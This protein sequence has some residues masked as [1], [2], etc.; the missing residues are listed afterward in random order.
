MKKSLLPF[1]STCLVVCV[2]GHSAL[3]SAQNNTMMLDIEAGL[4]HIFP[5]SFL[6][7]KIA[8][9]TVAAGV[10]YLYHYKSLGVEVN[11]FYA[12]N[13]I[14]ED[15][16]HGV[17]VGFGPSIRLHKGILN[18]KESAYISAGYFQN[19]LGQGLYAALRVRMRHFSF[20]LR[21]Q[22]DIGP[23]DNRVSAAMLTL[24]VPIKLY[25]K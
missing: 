16:F 4:Q 18:G 15:N 24:G 13:N 1:L 3:V 7:G 14:G 11:A 23:Q 9:T 22:S 6:D 17:N 12:N 2:I 20:G 8:Y 25:E 10:N 19:G 21:Y 5:S